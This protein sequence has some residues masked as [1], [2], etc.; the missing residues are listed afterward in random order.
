[1]QPSQNL[2]KGP[3]RLGRAHSLWFAQ[4][5]APLT[6]SDLPCNL[7]HRFTESQCLGREA[8]RTSVRCSECLYGGCGPILYGVD[9]P[10]N[11]LAN[12][13]QVRLLEDCCAL[14]R[15]R[16]DCFV[17]S[18][19]RTNALYNCYLKSAAG[20]RYTRT[21][22]FVA[23]WFPTTSLKG[24]EFAT[25]VAETKASLVYARSE[26]VGTAQICVLTMSAR[27]QKPSRTLLYA[28]SWASRGSVS[29]PSLV[30]GMAILVQ[31][32]T[33]VMTS[34]PFLRV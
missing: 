15:L 3:L 31:W 24:H 30:C 12:V 13:F 6:V 1:M 32:E 11:D 22:G 26:H 33:M 19:S 34:D 2:W 14:C 16:Q 29:I 27:M 17:W 8:K 28:R 7:R 25:P 21:S 23:R 5:L 20:G 9:Y 18:T 10:G 4:R